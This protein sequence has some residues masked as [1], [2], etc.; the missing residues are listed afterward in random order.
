MRGPQFSGTTWKGLE[1]VVL[2]DKVCHW[3]HHSQLAFPLP[4]ASR[5]D[6]NSQ[7]LLWRLPACLHHAPQD[8]VHGHILGKQGSN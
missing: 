4:H 5:S 8:D 7:L 1:G 6:A 2:L 3:G